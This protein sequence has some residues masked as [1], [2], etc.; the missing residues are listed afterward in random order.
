MKQKLIPLLLVAMLFA[1]CKPY[2]EQIIR[3]TLYADSTKT[4]PLA[5]DTLTFR[6]SNYM[7][8][9]AD[10][11]YLG[12]AVTDARGRWGFQ[13]I[14]GFDNPY[15]QEPAGAKFSMVEYFLLI[16]CGSD[17]LYWGG[18]GSFSSRNNDTIDL[19]PGKWQHPDWWY[20]QPDTTAIDTTV[21]DTTATKWKGGLL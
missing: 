18:A 5:G 17:T 2:S 3:G 20:Q 11:K 14:R 9:D 8:P 7:E 15:M 12:Q 19:W 21:V 1:A 6:E 16:T 13:Y 10:S 4:T